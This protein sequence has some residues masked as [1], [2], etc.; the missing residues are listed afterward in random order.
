MDS[1]DSNLTEGLLRR[2]VAACTR[3]LNGEGFLGYSGHVSG[4]LPDRPDAILI[5][6]FEQSRSEVSP[7]DLLIV[8]LDGKILQA[9]PGVEP[10][11]EVSIHLE[12]MR[13]RPDV[14]SALH[15]HPD[16]P[17]LFTLVEGVELKP[18]KN[19]AFR[20]ASGIPVHPDPAKI[21][22]PAQAKAMVKTLGECHAALLRAHGAI[23]VSD[24]VPGLMID[25]VHFVEN[26]QVLYQAMMIGKPVFLSEAEM[27]EIEKKQGRPRHIEKLWAYYVSR[28]LAAGYL[29]EA[30]GRGL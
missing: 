25:A 7:D 8:N 16:L 22:K 9:P 14:K 29:P 12:I 21:T 23:V 4:R 10:P 15:F 28:G 19:H 27:K 13:A 30:W 1:H 11:D 2:Q 24:S 3:M 6:S 20:F 5:Q 17:V 18:L 26:A